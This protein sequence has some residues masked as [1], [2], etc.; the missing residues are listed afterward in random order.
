MVNDFVPQTQQMYEGEKLSRE[1]LAR[2]EISRKTTSLNV[3]TVYSVEK[4]NSEYTQSGNS[5]VAVLPGIYQV[6]VKIEKTIVVRPKVSII[7]D[8][9]SGGRYLGDKPKAKKITGEIVINA[10][11]K[12]NKT[13]SLGGEENLVADEF[14]RVTGDWTPRFF[15]K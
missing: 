10:K 5:Y 8:T 15:V 9:G 2:I 12:K 1:N 14:G 6:K 13:Y 7:I 4:I 11:F 3:T